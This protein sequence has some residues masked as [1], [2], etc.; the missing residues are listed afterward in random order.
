MKSSVKIWLMMGLA[1]LL[2]ACGPAGKDAAGGT[3]SPLASAEWPLHGLT[4]QAQRFS[5]LTSIG[6]N[7]IGQLGLAWW[8]DLDT[9]AGQEATPIM[10]DGVLYIASAYNV[11][12][13]VDARSG[14][15]LWTFDP[16]TKEA[17]ARSCCGPVSRGVAVEGGRVYMGALD[18]RLIALDA[19]TGKPVWQVQTLDLSSPMAVNYTITGAPRI[20]KGKVIIGNGGAEFGARGY[21]SAYDM[22]TGK[23]VWRFYT[24]PG[25]PGS[26]DGAA[27]DEALAKIAAPTWFGQ[28]WRW[29]GGG[30]VWDAIEYDPE[31]DLLYIGVGN[32]SP[33]NH[34]IRS[35]GKGDNLFLSSIIA[36]KPDTGHYV[37]HY[38][39]TPGEAWDYTATQP[40]ILAD[41]TIDGAKRKVLMQAPKNGFFYVLDRA[42]GEL[43]AADPIARTSWASRIDL[44][45]GRPVENPD[46]RYYRSDKTV[47]VMPSSGGAHNWQP[48][49]F[50]PETGLVYI[51]VQDMGIPFRREA[52]IAR[53]AGVYNTGSQMVGGAAMNA[54][55]L[56][57]AMTQ[58]KGYLIAW[59]P[60][61][62]KVAWRREMAAT[63]NGGILATAGGL[64]F[65]GNGE[66]KLVAYDAKDGKPLWSFDAQTSIVAPP[67][68]Y[69]I[70]GVQYIAV[71]AGWGGAWPMLG[72]QFAE[73]PV[74]GVGT[75]RL[76]IFRLGGS[77]RLPAPEAIPA[78]PLDPPADTAP[79]ALIAKGDGLY[80]QYCLRCHG[81]GAVSASMVPDLRHSAMIA[82]GDSLDQ[83]L[84]GGV[85][86]PLGMPSFK[87][88]LTSA[89][90]AAIRAYLIHRANSDKSLAPSS[91]GR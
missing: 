72:G 18:G 46:A 81:I 49:A 20:V 79:A 75:N 10:R 4:T 33:T 76:L 40:I 84:I 12:R 70:D 60:V 56:K 68:A 45:T 89:D 41:L 65:Q 36:L 6:K 37:W 58:M 17:A 8:V 27:S 26:R 13:A 39:E 34:G 31:L 57:N 67:I 28:W 59:D 3:S 80:G 30:T 1:G 44:Q 91:P 86:A 55:D 23:L 50:S 14:K 64:V 29:G 38:Q 15:T 16:D 2:S 78:M 24:V 61:G 73:Q 82:D 32:G 87:G 52:D 21:V 54:A 71:M 85:L 42:T 7:N 53:K 5:P 66:R 11:V 9:N 47:V 74:N 83:I 69:A 88:V 62:R 22:T 90:T 19:K 77:A 63:F 43:L 48:M 35:E 25:K 51:P